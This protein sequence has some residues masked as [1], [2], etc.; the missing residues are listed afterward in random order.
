M[1]I[2][3]PKFESGTI[4]LHPVQPGEDGRLPCDP[5]VRP[6]DADAVKNGF[7]NALDWYSYSTGGDRKD[8]KLVKQHFD[9]LPE[10]F[11]S[12]SDSDIDDEKLGEFFRETLKHDKGDSSVYLPTEEDDDEFDMTQKL[13]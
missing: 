13:A 11:P 7:K 8:P 4:H 3:N 2:K 9:Q 10:E 12:D 5:N 6:S 1:G